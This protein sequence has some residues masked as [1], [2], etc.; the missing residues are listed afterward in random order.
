MPPP[1]I[2]ALPRPD[3]CSSSP[4]AGAA[5]AGEVLDEPV[6]GGG[7]LLI[8]IIILDVVNG[9]QPGAQITQIARIARIAQM[10]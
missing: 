10:G 5:P 1:I 9:C 4:L 8:P 2:A 6:G 3:D 7:L